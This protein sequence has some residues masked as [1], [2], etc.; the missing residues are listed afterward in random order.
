MPPSKCL[1]HF[2]ADYTAG[3]S[4]PALTAHLS[5]ERELYVVHKFNTDPVARVGGIGVYSGFMAML[6]EDLGKCISPLIIRQPPS[7]P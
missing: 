6:A 4:L 2:P 7:C 3:Y 5:A 1:S